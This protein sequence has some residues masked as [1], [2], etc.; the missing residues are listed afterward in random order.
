MTVVFG[1]EL[2]FAT[3]LFSILCALIEILILRKKYKP[4]NLLQIPVIIIFGL[5]MS[6]CVNIVRNIPDPTNFVVILIL[7]LI[8]TVFISVGV[9]IYLSAGYIPLPT[10][11]LMLVF[12]EITNTKFAT[13]KVIGNVN[14]VDISLTTCLIAIHSLG[15]IGFGTIISAFLVGTEVKFITKKFGGSVRKLTGK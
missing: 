15:S 8:S 14:M 3:T 10:E 13:W 6:S 1:M 2:G 4:I 11:G 5:F 7:I 12:A 9:F